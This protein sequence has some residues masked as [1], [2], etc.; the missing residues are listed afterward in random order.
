MKGKESL[1][2]LN[3]NGRLHIKIYAL[4]ENDYHKG[5]Q[6]SSTGIQSRNKRREEKA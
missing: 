5:N 1:K 3:A 4:I 6:R 2:I